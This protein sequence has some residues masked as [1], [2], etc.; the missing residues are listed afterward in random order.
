M[1]G[2]SPSATL[3][4]GV[5]Q[6][7]SDFDWQRPRHCTFLLTYF[8]KFTMKSE[9]ESISYESFCDFAWGHLEDVFELDCEEGLPGFSP[10]VEFVQGCAFVSLFELEQDE[11]IE[12]FG[13]TL[14]ELHG[15]LMQEF[16]D[17][18]LLNNLGISKHAKGGI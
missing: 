1:C 13:F 2:N 18:F 17:E 6:A 5:F 15:N 7:L 8:F 3:Y 16:V 11:Q 12:C 14:S 10:Y 9:I 4:I